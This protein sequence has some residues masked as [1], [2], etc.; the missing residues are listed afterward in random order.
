LHDWLCIARQKIKRTQNIRVC[1]AIT[2][3]ALCHNVTPV[4]ETN[5][6]TGVREIAYQASSPDEIALVK[7]TEKV[8]ITLTSR[9]FSNMV[10][11]HPDGAEEVCVHLALLLVN[12]A[13]AWRA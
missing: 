11:T 4:L 13:Y 2:A 9:T 7:F 8:G 12:Y 5:E 6:E 1:E 10:I 3:L